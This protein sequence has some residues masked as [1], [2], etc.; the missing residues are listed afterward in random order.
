MNYHTNMSFVSSHR[1]FISMKKWYVTQID[2]L[3]IMCN[4]KKCNIFHDVPIDTYIFYIPNYS[5]SIFY[6]KIILYVF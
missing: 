6:S 4:K 2:Q 5:N 1:Y 3:K